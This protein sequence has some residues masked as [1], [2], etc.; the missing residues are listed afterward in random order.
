MN[1][2]PIGIDCGVADALKKLNIR[3]H[4]LPFDWNVSYS[5]ISD[6]IRND[7]KDFIPTKRFGIQNN[8]IYCSV[9][10]KY[11]TLFIHEDWMKDKIKEQ[12][13]YQRRINRFRDL[14]SKYKDGN[15]TLY[16]I[17]KGH[18]FHHHAEYYY[19][20]DIESAKELSI[21]LKE[22]YPNLN[23]KIYII[24]CCKTCYDCEENYTNDDKNIIIINNTKNIK[25]T[26]R[27]DEL[28]N[29]IKNNILPEITS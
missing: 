5:G 19:K 29:C 4:A 18:M 2:I 21:I 15:E 16:F 11:N 9:Y 8:G 3:Q 25:I 12:E 14:I 24:L 1:I 17:R 6:I 27:C 26:D 23:Y 10:N 28:Y 20:D 7:F 22:L 13:K